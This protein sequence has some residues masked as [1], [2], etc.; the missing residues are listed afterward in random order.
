[1][2]TLWFATGSAVP[3]LRRDTLLDAAR[4][5]IDGHALR[6]SAGV[7]SPHDGV[8]VLRVLAP[9]VEPV[10]NLLA[11]VWAEWRRAA[12]QLSGCTPRVWRT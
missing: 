10:M 6:P 2:G 7:S 5:V 1:M 4:A 3:D 12:W 11:A 9:R 8:I